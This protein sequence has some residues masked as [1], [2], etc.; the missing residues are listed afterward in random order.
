[1]HKIFRAASLCLALLLLAAGAAAEGAKISIGTPAQLYDFLVNQ[2]DATGKLTKDLTLTEENW[3]RAEIVNTGL[4]L[5]LN[6]KKIYDTRMNN[7]MLMWVKSS[8]QLTITGNGTIEKL[9]HGQNM[10]YS[11]G[12]LNILNGNYKY[13]AFDWNIDC[14]KDGHGAHATNFQKMGCLF[15][16]RRNSTD[17]PNG[18]INVYGGTFD[19]GVQNPE[20]VAEK[21]PTKRDQV[22]FAIFNHQESNPDA[23]NI[24]GGTIIHANPIQGDA[25]GWASNGKKN[26]FLHQQ[27]VEQAEKGEYPAPYSIKKGKSGKFDTYKT[28]YPFSMQ[29]KKIVTCADDETALK[30]SGF[31]ITLKDVKT[32]KKKTVTTGADG[33]ATFNFTAA[34]MFK[35]YT[36]TEVK[37]NKPGM[38]YSTLKYNLKVDQDPTMDYKPILVLTLNGNEVEDGIAVFENMYD[39]TAAVG[40]KPQDLPK[41]GDNSP[42]V[43]MISLLSLISSLMILRRR[44]AMN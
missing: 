25:N 2:K 36:I 8:G 3:T 13:T 34:D 4:T 38:T 12:I 9:D 24:Y 43:L 23:I 5:D 28:T 20:W 44:S 35:T 42:I 26:L 37:G 21:N 39:P 33:T 19:S 7:S 11:D 18:S 17:F 6:G 32:G 15:C 40:T 30:P 16:G 41:T 1:M 29:V 14:L 10:I 31:S 27:T 22:M